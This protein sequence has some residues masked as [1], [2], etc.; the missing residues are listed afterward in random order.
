MMAK[1]PP[2]PPQEPPLAPAAAPVCPYSS[3]NDVAGYR[4]SVLKAYEYL[5]MM[6]QVL[7][8]TMIRDVIDEYHA[9]PSR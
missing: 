5:P 3:G 6:P 9:V 7:V 2:E 8:N 4:R 1:R